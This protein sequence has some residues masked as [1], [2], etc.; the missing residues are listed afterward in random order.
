MNPAFDDAYL[1]AL[2]R[3][4]PV[5]EEHLVCYFS[6]TLKGHLR[7]R[8]RCTQAVEDG[9]QE[10][11]FRVLTYFRAGKT[12]RAASNLPAFVNSVSIN[13]S[14]ELLRAETRDEP[15]DKDFDCAPDI[16]ANPE[17]SVIARERAETIRRTLVQLSL[18]DQQIL[19]SVFLKE[20]DKDQICEELCTTRDHLRVLLYRA[21]RRFR[22]AAEQNQTIARPGRRVRRNFRVRSGAGTCRVTDSMIRVLTRMIPLN[23]MVCHRIDKVP[24][25]QIS[26][27]P[28]SSRR[29]NLFARH[30]SVYP[31]EIGR[32]CSR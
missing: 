17:L 15:L 27:W 6:K 8:L 29:W 14:L 20:A 26:P 7:R 24:L 23:E 2:Q 19:E 10:T 5:I 21:R 13:V 25:E 32:S 3:H 31:P 30:Y 11:L 9:T 12:L 1:A 16:R 18:K 22:A 28:Y 4:D